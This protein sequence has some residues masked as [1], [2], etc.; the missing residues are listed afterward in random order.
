M[1]LAMD[2]LHFDNRF[3]AELPG[4]TSGSTERRQ[5][6]GVAW[7]AAHP[8]PVRQPQLLAHSRAVAELVGLSEQDIQSPRF[9]RIFGGCEVLPAMAPFAAC[10][11]GHQFGHWAGQL[12]DGRALT[13]GEVVNA[14]GER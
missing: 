2:H 14:R 13:L 5:T 7:S 10:Y 9:A 3:V 4:D 1:V 8:T 11:G 6:P 12:G